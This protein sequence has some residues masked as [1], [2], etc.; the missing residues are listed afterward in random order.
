MDLTALGIAVLVALGLL[1]ADAVIHSENLIIEVVAPPRGDKISIDDATLE[2]TFESQ[3]RAIS[4]TQSLVSP[5]EIRASRR[6]GIG[7]ALAE[8]ARVQGVARALQVE[9]GYDPARLRL[10]LFLQ[11]GAVRGLVSGAGKSQD[12]FDLVLSPRDDESLPEFVRRTAVFGAARIA[13][14]TTALYLVQQHA[15]DKDFTGVKALL[16]RIMPRMAPAP[17]NRQRALFEN[18]SGIVQ[19]FENDPKSAKA[20]FSA[21][22]A[23]DPTNPAAALN[24][25]FAEIEIDEYA[26]AAERMERLVRDAPPQNNVLHGTMYMTWAAANMGLKD[27][28][29]ADA[30]MAKA[31]EL[32]PTSATGYDLWAEVK[33]LLGDHDAAAKLRHKAL[34]ETADRFENYAEIAAL[35]FHLGW[36]ND[37][38]VTRN[39]FATVD[40]VT[41]H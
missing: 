12:D 1:S 24:L 3:L 20:S 34:A 7:M 8:A 4:D 16:A 10:A 33:E 39:R 6:Q 25:A 2:M 9:L 22:V 29:R 17:I 19:L 37:V 38:P 35:Y 23:S 26:A 30:L 31:L 27:A 40:A 28:A 18:V 15:H 36:Q 5:P 41:S 21:A 32:Y 13:P 14:Y 11:N